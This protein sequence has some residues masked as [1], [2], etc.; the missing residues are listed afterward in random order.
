MRIVTRPDFDGIVCA[1]LLY[2]VEDITAPMLWLEPGEIQDRRESIG[3]EDILANLPY[4]DRC[5]MWF[6][7]HVSNQ[8]DRSF[9]GEF[10]I[11]PS[12]AG[13]IHNY[14][15]ERFRR[16][17]TEL[18]AAADKVDSAD[19]TEQEVHHPEE[20][21]YIILS[22][23]VVGTADAEADYWD[24]LVEL[25]RHSDLPTVLSDAQVKERCDRTVADN[26]TYGRL[27]EN[28][29]HLEGQVS[30][31]DFRSL[32]PTPRGNRFLV[33]SLFPGTNV[34]AC[35]LHKEGDR[36]RIMVKLGHSIFNRTCNVNVGQLLSQFG[37]GGHRGAGSC[38]FPLGDA[39]KSIKA[40]VDILVTNV[41]DA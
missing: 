15:G 27:L 25:L 2:E 31:T 30:V 8:A 4:D 12:A 36:E 17:H 6:D 20:Y 11:A 13:V 26:A 1:V 9:E 5:G 41:A 14:Y 28:H 39:D 34:N 32:D 18:V 7:H 22:M 40:I 35:I 23:T 29:T 3:P 38:S 19:F 33:Y 10:R 37:G 24:R 16:D 21:P